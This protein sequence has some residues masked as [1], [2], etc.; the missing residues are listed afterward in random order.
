MKK[1]ASLSLLPLVFVMFLLFCSAAVEAQ[2]PGGR[3]CKEE[4]MS[5]VECEPKR[6]DY[7]CKAAHRD[8]KVVLGNCDEK[9]KFICDCHWVCGS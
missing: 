6:C 5:R 4:L 8:K 9:K 2:W 3:W 1:P 7:F